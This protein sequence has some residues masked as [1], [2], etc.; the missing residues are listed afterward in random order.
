[1]TQQRARTTV[2]TLIVASA[3][4]CGA[5]F[6]TACKKGAD[7]KMEEMVTIM[8]EMGNAITSANGDCPKMANNLEAFANKRSDDLKELKAWADAAKNDKAQAEEM[9]KNMSKYQ[10]RL[11]KVMPAMMG[12]MKCADDPKIKALN[13]KLKGIM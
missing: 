2:R 7:G 10:S 3:I 6:G 8:E 4:A 12:M 9:A 5:L 13:E 1:M 11:E